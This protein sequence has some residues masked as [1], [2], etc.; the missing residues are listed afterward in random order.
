MCIFCEIISGEQPANIIYEDE[1]TLAFLDIYPVTPGHILVI[2][3][4]HQPLLEE[5]SP[6]LAGYLMRIGQKMGTALRSSTLT[7]E[8]VSY[9]LSDGRAAGQEIEHVH[10]HV[11]PRYK[12]D[13]VY[14]C[15]DPKSR[16]NPG[17]EEL[18]KIAKKIGAGVEKVS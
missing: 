2:P 9:V 17:P 11:F 16:G 13:G 12:G 3:K 6:E 7:C 15:L 4:Q 8:G 14:S 10:L 18:R 5:S 1:L